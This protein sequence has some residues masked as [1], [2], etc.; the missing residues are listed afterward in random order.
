[1][2]V[3]A[4]VLTKNEANIISRCLQSL[5]WCDEILVIDDNSTDETIKI[6]QELGAKVITRKLQGD[7][8]AQRNF[9]LRQAQ[10]EWMLFVDADEVVSPELIN[11]IQAV[12]NQPKDINEFYIPRKDY[13]LG[14]WLSFGETANARFIRLAKKDS[15]KWQRPVHEV[16]Q[17]KG[18]TGQLQSPLW[19]YAHP[20][21]AEFITHINFWTDINVMYFYQQSIKVHWWQILLYPSGKFLLN[22]VLK[23]GFLD[24]MPGLILALGMSFHSFLTRAKVYVK[25]K[26]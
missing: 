3:S 14:K 19:H 21:I 15:G 18:K 17:I 1:M 4:V 20:T 23:L 7:F 22:Y 13:F 10:G 12:L 2:K 26:M 9:A 24:G 16:W 25:C 11:E 6:A 8:A 5:S